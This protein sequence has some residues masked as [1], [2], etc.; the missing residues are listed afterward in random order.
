[1]LRPARWSRTSTACLLWCNS[2]S[3]T[4]KIWRFNMQFI[5]RLRSRSVLND[6]YADVLGKCAMSVFDPV[7]H[8]RL[9]AS[10][11]M[12]MPNTFFVCAT[13]ACPCVLDRDTLMRTT[14]LYTW[15]YKRLCVY[16]RTAFVCVRFNGMLKKLG[17][18]CGETEVEW[19]RQRLR[20]Y[21]I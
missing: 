20:H 7:K 13:L 11:I 8:E 1:M 12:R 14:L 4:N 3:Q 21:C 16:A 17:H 6:F 15:T 10:S 19:K 5:S 18:V 2:Y 9:H